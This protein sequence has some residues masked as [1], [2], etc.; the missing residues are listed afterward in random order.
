MYLYS[1]HFDSDKIK[2][3]FPRHVNAPTLSE[4]QVHDLRA[5]DVRVFVS[6]SQVPLGLS[7]RAP[8]ASST[9][10]NSMSSMDHTNDE[11]ALKEETKA[12]ATQNDDNGDEIDLDDLL[13]GTCAHFSRRHCS[14]C[15]LEP[16]MCIAWSRSHAHT[17]CSRRAR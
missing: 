10:S 8:H 4:P 13:D 16:I 17:L 9:T 6:S 7:V 11:R 5:I 12:P 15:V 2:V 14:H 3:S 1:Q